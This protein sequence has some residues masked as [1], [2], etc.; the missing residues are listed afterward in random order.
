MIKFHTCTAD[1]QKWGQY[2]PWLTRMNLYFIH[3]SH[4]KEQKQTNKQTKQKNKAIGQDTCATAVW[5]CKLDKH[6]LCLN[7][8]QAMKKT[9]GHTK[10]LYMKLT[11]TIIFNKIKRANIIILSYENGISVLLRNENYFP[12]KISAQ[13]FEFWVTEGKGLWLSSCWR[14]ERN[15]RFCPTSIEAVPVPARWM[16]SPPSASHPASQTG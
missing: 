6:W 3:F 12:I 7:N 13:G 5:S 9:H 14:K 16:Q 8:P 1:T 10:T 11:N 15:I 4:W 2:L